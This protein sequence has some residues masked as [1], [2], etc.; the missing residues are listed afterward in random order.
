MFDILTIF[1]KND[2]T[3]NENTSL[4]MEFVER[5]LE[6]LIESLRTLSGDLYSI[7]GELDGCS[8]ASV[9]NVYY[10]GGSIHF[11]LAISQRGRK[12]FKRVLK[13]VMLQSGFYAKYLEES[14]RLFLP[15]RLRIIVI[16]LYLRQNGK[17]DYLA[18]NALLDEIVKAE[19]KIIEFGGWVPCLGDEK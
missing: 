12:S 19:E 4:T 15:Q 18:S 17:D 10:A 11:S 9:E 13:L 5:T 2:K 14:H 8:H 1:K 6:A 3:A 7:D 16:E